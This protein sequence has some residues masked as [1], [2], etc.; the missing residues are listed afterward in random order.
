M[1]S[2]SSE[3][4]VRVRSI[5][6]SPRLTWWDTGSSSRSLEVQHLAAGAHAG[7]PQQRPQARQQ[8][9]QRKGLHDVVVRA[10]VEPGHAVGDRVPRS[11]HQHRRAVAPGAHRAAHLEAVHCPASSRRAPPRR[12][13]PCERLARACS[14]SAARVISYPSRRSARSRESRTAGSSSTTRIRMAPSVTPETELSLNCAA[15]ADS[16]RGLPNRLG[17]GFALRSAARSVDGRDEVKL[18]GRPRKGSVYAGSN[19]IAPDHAPHRLG[20]LVHAPLLRRV[21]GG[22]PRP[23]SPVRSPPTRCRAAASSW[24]RVPMESTSAST[25]GTPAA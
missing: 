23:D 16:G 17:P 3:N 10:G 21:R 25:P 5:N 8:L 4:S 20:P 13:R 7:A 9:V 15:E 11:Q 14:P 24:V 22:R 2:S 18:A 19:F 1:K 12:C 6:R